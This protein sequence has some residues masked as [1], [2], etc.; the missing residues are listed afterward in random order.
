M[1]SKA[2]VKIPV[3]ILAVIMWWQCKTCAAYVVPGNTTPDDDRYFDKEVRKYF[4]SH[5]KDC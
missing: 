2:M 3:L 4:E 1:N 5:F